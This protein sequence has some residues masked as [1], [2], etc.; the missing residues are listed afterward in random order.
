MKIT[1]VP[2]AKLPY[3]DTCW[4][5]IEGPD[6]KAYAVACCEHSSGGSAFIT[7][8]D[9]ATR[10]LEYLLDVAEAVGEPPSTGR[11]TQCKIH[12]SM[13]VDDDGIL[14]AATHLSGPAIDQPFYNPWGTF[15]DPLRSFVGARMLAYDIGREKVLWTDTLIPYEGC[16]CLAF[17]RQRRLMYA[18]GYPR[19]HFYVYELDRRRRTDLGRIGSVNPQAIWLDQRGWAYTTNDD[20]RIVLC[21]PTSDGW[22]L[23]ESDVRAPHA[24]YQTGWHNVVYDVVQVPGQ[25]AVA[26]CMW[27]TDPRLF[28]LEHAADPAAMRMHDLGPAHVG[29]DDYAN[30]GFNDDHV[31]G[32][33]F[34]AAGQLLYCISRPGRGSSMFPDRSATLKRMDLATRQVRDVCALKDEAGVEIP[35]V[36]RMVRIGRR[37]LVMG[38]VGH[39]PTGVLHVELDDDL[40]AGPLAATPRRYWG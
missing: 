10:K 2:F 23:R 7:R 36:S 13:I 4:S 14:Y 15:D 37:H 17:D 33:A 21:R 39:M 27:N 25:D 29:I 30:R 40:A 35:Y 19:D 8:Y 20:G 18:V 32:L 1:Y 22:D 34:D 12:Y 26:G 31:G 28:L 9:P 3:T 11:A 24:P 6:D 5:L 16:R 38:V